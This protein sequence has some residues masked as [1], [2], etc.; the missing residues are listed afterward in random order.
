MTQDEF[1]LLETIAET[2]LHTIKVKTKDSNLIGTVECV[3]RNGNITIANSY[4]VRTTNISNIELL[5]K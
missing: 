2:F 4:S 1:I 3:F 5:T